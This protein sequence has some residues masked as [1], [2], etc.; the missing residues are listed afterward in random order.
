MQR[1]TGRPR[2]RLIP[3]TETT[4]S[5]SA[6]VPSADQA[7]RLHLSDKALELELLGGFALREASSECR[8]LPKKAQALLAYLAIQARPISREQLATLLWP[9]SGSDQARRSLRQCLMSLRSALHPYTDQ[10][11]IAD[12]SAI[13]LV[14]GD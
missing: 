5:R 11:L 1:K 13:R 9:D 6:S 8:Q 14:S 4:K 2:L 12:T 10:T 7:G 3:S